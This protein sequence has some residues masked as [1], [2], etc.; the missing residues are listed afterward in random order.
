MLH[1]RKMSLFRRA[2]VG[3]WRGAVS[4]FPPPCAAGRGAKHQQPPERDVMDLCETYIKNVPLRKVLLMNS[5][6]TCS[7]C[8]TVRKHYVSKKTNAHDRCV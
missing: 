2:A 5:M 4:P 1:S 8:K 6:C 7:M 3:C